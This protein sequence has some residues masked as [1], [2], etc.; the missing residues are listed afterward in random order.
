[1]RRLGSVVYLAAFL[2][3]VH[4]ESGKGRKIRPLQQGQKPWF[5]EAG[6]GRGL[7]RSNMSTLDLTKNSTVSK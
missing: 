7:N 6:E 3:G 1:M 5:L 2:A 4:G